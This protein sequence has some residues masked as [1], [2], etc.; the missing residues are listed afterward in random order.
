MLTIRTADQIRGARN[1]TSFRS[2]AVSTGV[3]VWRAD[4]RRVVQAE[5]RLANSETRRRWHNLK[6][7]TWVEQQGKGVE[8]LRA[9]E[10]PG[11]WRAQQAR[12]AEVDEMLVRARKA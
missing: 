9:Q 12:V 2:C 11:F 3:S 4:A 8:D 1:L 5:E 7:Y 10:D 6:Y